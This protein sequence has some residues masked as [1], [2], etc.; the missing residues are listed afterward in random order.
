MRLI[1]ALL[2]S[3]I[4]GFISGLVVCMLLRAWEHKS[5][6]LRNLSADQR[7]A[8]NDNYL[9]I[10][11]CVCAVVAALSLIIMATRGVPLPP[12]GTFAD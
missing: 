2:C 1:E 5:P 3:A 6:M 9:R 7:Q 12:P 8:V 4:V 11:V 10:L